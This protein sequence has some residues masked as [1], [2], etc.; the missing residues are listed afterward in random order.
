MKRLLWKEGGVSTYIESDGGKHTIVR[1]ED[2][3]PALDRNKALQNNPEYGR[4]GIQSGMQHIAFIPNT[5]LE[6][7]YHQGL[8]KSPLMT[9]PGDDKRA[10]DLLNGPDWKFLKVWAGKV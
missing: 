9:A 1:V 2:L 3:T 8:I 6:M 5:I 7:W 10:R 4:R